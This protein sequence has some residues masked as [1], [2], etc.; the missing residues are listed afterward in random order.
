MRLKDLRQARGE[1]QA[2]IA[3]LLGISRAA[4]ANIEN[5]KREPSFKTVDI[6]ARHFH[7]SVDYL[8]GRSDSPTPARDDLFKM[9]AEIAD[10]EELL[11]ILDLVNKKLQE[12]RVKK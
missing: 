5:G 12:R 4:L 8:L 9:V 2:Q 11:A 1:T 10:P 6:L 7:V 3:Q